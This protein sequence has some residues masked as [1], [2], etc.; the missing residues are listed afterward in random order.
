MPLS[1]AAI[2][3]AKPRAK[4]FK[5]TDGDGMYLLVNSNGS[6][7]W[8]M[9]YRFG[10]KRKTL[11]LGVYPNVTIEHAREQK[12][13]ARRLLADGTDPSAVRRKAKARR[14]V[15]LAASD[16]HAPPHLTV[17]PNGMIEIWIGRK[18]L[19]YYPQVSALP[20]RIFFKLPILLKI[21]C[22]HSGR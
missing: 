12:D 6:R 15:E 11:A 5:L 16:Q 22:L 1:E 18:S 3:N 10:D 14:K 20:A 21:P 13:E 9:D 2:V 17:H 8:R 19:Y 4:P 7:L